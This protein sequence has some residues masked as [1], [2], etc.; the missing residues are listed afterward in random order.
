MLLRHLLL[1][2]P[3]SVSHPG[4]VCLCSVKHLCTW[5]RPAL[6]AVTFWVLRCRIQSIYVPGLA[7]VVLPLWA[8][9]PAGGVYMVRLVFPWVTSVKNGAGLKQEPKVLLQVWWITARCHNA[10]CCFLPKE[11]LMHCSAEKDKT[12][13][14]HLE[15]Q[16]LTFVARE[17]S[18]EVGLRF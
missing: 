2:T 9:S 13:R 12:E 6:C 3:T 4:M 1:Q 7:Q 5:L 15:Y 11:G 16:K 18:Y 14:Q 10:A 17:I 8:W